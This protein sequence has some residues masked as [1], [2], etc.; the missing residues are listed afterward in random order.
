MDRDVLHASMHALVLRTGTELPADVVQAL[1]AAWENEAPDS[2]ARE[3]LGIM[4]ESAELSQAQALPICQDTGSLLAVVSAGSAEEMR[5]IEDALRAAVR[6]LTDE[7]ILRQNCVDALSDRNTGTNMGTHVPQIHFHPAAGPVTVRLMLKGGG[8]ENMSAQYSL[9]SKELKAGRDFDGVRR[10]VLDAVFRAQGKGCAPG[11]L[12][13]CIGGDRASGHVLAKEQ[14]F[15]KLPDVNPEPALARLEE[16]IRSQANR[17]GIGPM[18][19]TGRTTVLGVK[20]VA[21]GRHPASYFVTV[22]YSCWA[23]RRYSMELDERGGI[24]KWL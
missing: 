17:L 3:T 18:G 2:V 12:G 22:S 11:I 24:A 20:A 23:T 10:C 21:A 13:L 1:Q 14:L 5:A 19:L 16:D 6:V 9:P 7:G 4:R 15:R 8:S